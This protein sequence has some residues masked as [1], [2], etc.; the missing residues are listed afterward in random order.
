MPN[1]PWT[2]ASL[3]SNPFFQLDDIFPHNSK[4]KYFFDRELAD[5]KLC[6]KQIDWQLGT[7]N[8]VE[9][10][11]IQFW[12][13]R[14]CALF[15]CLSDE[16]SVLKTVAGRRK[17]RPLEE[18]KEDRDA[19]KEPM[20]GKKGSQ[21]GREKKK[22][23]RFYSYLSTFGL[24]YKPL[25]VSRNLIDI[26]FSLPLAT[27]ESFLF[28]VEREKLSVESMTKDLYQTQKCPGVFGFTNSTAA[29]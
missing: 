4:L 15:N 18:K 24:N 26:F 9:G 11:T 8:F 10:Y 22:R 2:T 7:N 14:P 27:W 29:T 28:L 21:G 20:K 5:V 13:I 1:V 17:K 23:A 6:D 25:I 12:G 3:N 16:K 19:R